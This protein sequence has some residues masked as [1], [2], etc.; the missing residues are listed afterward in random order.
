MRCVDNYH[1]GTLKLHGRIKME[2]VG[3]SETSVPNYQTRRHVTRDGLVQTG[4]RFHLTSIVLD[5]TPQEEITHFQVWY[6]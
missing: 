4:S 6:L 2:E 3:F 5:E 1:E